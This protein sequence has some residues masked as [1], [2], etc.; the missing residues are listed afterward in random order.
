MYVSTYEK[1]EKNFKKV[2]KVFKKY[3]VTKEQQK[4][5]Y[6]MFLEYEDDLDKDLLKELRE[7]CKQYGLTVNQV[8]NYLDFAGIGYID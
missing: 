8:C 5:M 6:D 1:D 4:E 3:G 2:D 7:M